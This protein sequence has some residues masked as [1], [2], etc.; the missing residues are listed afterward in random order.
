MYVMPVMFL[1]YVM[2]SAWLNFWTETLQNKPGLHVV[3]DPLADKGAGDISS[4]ALNAHSGKLG[5][6]RYFS[7][8][9]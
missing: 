5:Q 9:A 7:A 3:R 8:L 1:P 2:F 6:P 4:A